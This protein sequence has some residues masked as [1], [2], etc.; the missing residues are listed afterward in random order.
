MVTSRKSLRRGLE[1]ENAEI[2]SMRKAAERW[3]KSQ[4]WTDVQT[5]TRMDLGLAVPAVISV[6]RASYSRGVGEARLKRIWVV[7]GDVPTAAFDAE[8]I[9]TAVEALKW[10]CTLMMRWAAAILRPSSRK[11]QVY[12]VEARRTK[13]NALA[14]QSRITFLRRRVIPA[15]RSSLAPKVRL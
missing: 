9:D 14:L 5:P 3:L 10:Y 6:W 7:S 13:A 15:F 12:P 1:P 11:L 8:N 2:R 4:P